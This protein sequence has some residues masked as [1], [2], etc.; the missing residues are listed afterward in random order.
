VNGAG[1]VVAFESFGQKDQDFSTQLTRI[2][3]SGAELLYLPNYYNSS[4]NGGNS[5]GN[6]SPAGN[7]RCWR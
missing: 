3:N 5:G 2:V 1:S 7:S 6:S 4:M